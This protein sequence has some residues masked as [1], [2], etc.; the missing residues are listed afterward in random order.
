MRPSLASPPA[1]RPAHRPALRPALRL[2]AALTAPVLLAACVAPRTEIAACPA[3]NLHLTARKDAAAVGRHT[4][5]IDGPMKALLAGIGAP[6][7]ALAVTAQG[8][9]SSINLY[10]DPLSLSGP[11][12][13]PEFP[14]V[15]QARLRVGS[16]S[17]TVTALAA[18]R[19]AELSD[20]PGGIAGEPGGPTGPGFLDRPLGEI[21]P[22]AAEI[23]EWSQATLRR[24]LSHTALAARDAEPFDQAAIDALPAAAGSHPA[25]HPRH[26]FAGYRGIS[27]KL[28]SAPASPNPPPE[29]ARY[30]NIGFMLAGAAIDWQVLAREGASPSGNADGYER[31]VWRELGIGAPLSG[32]LSLLSMC[33]APDWRSAATA[34][35]AVGFDETGAALPPPDESGW[36]G[37]AG[38]WT[39]TIGD[40][41]RLIA[42]I[43]RTGL[44]SA[45]STSAMLERLGTGPAADPAFWGLGV[46]RG[47]GGSGA[48]RHGKGGDILGFTSDFIAV[49]GRGLGA[50]VVCTGRELDHVAIRATLE[51]IVAACLR[52]PPSARPEYCRTDG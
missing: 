41:G 5:G 51:G 4:E 1:H 8:R 10:G 32:E 18:L 49:S 23:P 47:G 48:L 25:I 13:Y 27:P 9:L 44:I 6:S 2:A 38:G 20:G 16:I 33:L 43:E 42:V 22:P 24:L 17:K 26:A 12:A 36:A 28:V 29:T 34:N 40:L 39:M 7:C 45:A 3:S 15:A 30:S 11:Q 46:W 35:I 14:A 52:N 19:L 31:F 50:A 37:P 21:Y